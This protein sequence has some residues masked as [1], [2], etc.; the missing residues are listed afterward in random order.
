MSEKHD[1]ITLYQ[2]GGYQVVCRK[3]GLA[4]PWKRAGER[5]SGCMAVLALAFACVF[6][7]FVAWIIARELWGVAVADITALL[8]YGIALVVSVCCIGGPMPHEADEPEVQ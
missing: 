3:C 4:G 7:A 1:W 5:G 2:D 6:P 8:C